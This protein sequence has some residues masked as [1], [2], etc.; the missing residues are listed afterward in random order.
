MTVINRAGRPFLN[1]DK[2]SESRMPWSSLFHS[3]IV[4]GKNGILKELCFALKMKWES[5]IK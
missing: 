3:E 2:L 1:I 5:C 4:E